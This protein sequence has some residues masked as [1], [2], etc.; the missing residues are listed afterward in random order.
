MFLI[1]QAVLLL[2]TNPGNLSW[3]FWVK[4]SNEKRKQKLA[5]SQLEICFKIWE[6]FRKLRRNMFWSYQSSQTK[7]DGLCG[8]LGLAHSTGRTP[9]ARCLGSSQTSPGLATEAGSAFHRI[10]VLEQRC[11]VTQKCSEEGKYSD[12]TPCLDANDRRQ[13]FS[14]IDCCQGGMEISSLAPA[15]HLERESGDKRQDQKPGPQRQVA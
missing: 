3:S 2:L 15:G 4:L 11:I 6:V 8:F 13:K 14:E 10:Q 1:I 5:N 7:V 9:V 12:C